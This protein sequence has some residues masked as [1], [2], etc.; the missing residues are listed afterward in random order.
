MDFGWDI[1]LGFAVYVLF[2]IGWVFARCKD[3]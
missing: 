2:C 1:K 3:E